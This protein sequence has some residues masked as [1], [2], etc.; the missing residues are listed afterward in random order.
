[1]SVCPDQGRSVQEYNMQMGSAWPPEARRGQDQREQLASARHHAF[2]LHVLLHT[3]Q[4][5]LGVGATIAPF[6]YEAQGYTEVNENREES[7]TFSFMP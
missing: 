2:T 3:L 5:A 6:S 1:M 4:Q 7:H